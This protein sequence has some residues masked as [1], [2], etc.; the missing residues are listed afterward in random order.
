MLISTPYASRSCSHKPRPKDYPIYMPLVHLSDQSIDLVLTVTEIT[1]LNEV[2]EFSS[3]ETASWVAKL[4][5]PEEVGGLLEVWT[6]G[7]DLVDQ[8][9]HADDSVFA[10]A[11]L[12]NGV[13]GK[14]NALL[15]DLSVSALV[16]ELT[17]SLEVRVSVGDPWLNNL[18]HLKGSLSHANK[19]TIVD[20]EKT[21]ELEDLSWFWGNLVDTG[22][23]LTEVQFNMIRACLPLDTDNEDQLLLSRDVER[24]LLFGDTSETNLLALLVTVLLDVLLGTLEDD[25]TLF[26][27]SL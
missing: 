13:V 26:L 17:N 27:L 25:T 10:K 16:D 5:W 7:E 9:L 14:G 3:A 11:S 21:K 18:Q 8:I 23:G 2:T 24:A 15:L 20:L 12:N 1:T 6:D 19:D 22:F 4:E